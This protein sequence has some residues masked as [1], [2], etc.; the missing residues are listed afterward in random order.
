[1]NIQSMREA[2]NVPPEYTTCDERRRKEI[3]LRL[4]TEYRLRAAMTAKP[5]EP[6]KWSGLQMNGHSRAKGKSYNYLLGTSAPRRNAALLFIERNPSVTNAEVQK[7]A[8]YSTRK[9]CRYMLLTCERSGLLQSTADR[10]KFKKYRITD[11][12]RKLLRDLELTE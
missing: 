10:G 2:V 4:L 12:G 7:E 8:R 3:L 1:M 6:D 5:P 9:S 11:L